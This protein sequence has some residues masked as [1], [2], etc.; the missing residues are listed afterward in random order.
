MSHRI[1]T[2]TPKAPGE[3]RKWHNWSGSVTGHPKNFAQPQSVEE[4]RQI[5]QQTAKAGGQLRVVGAGHSFTPLVQTDDTLLSL[6]NWQGIEHIEKDENQHDI[7]TVRAGTRLNHLG[8]LLHANG[9][10]QENL[11]DIDVQSIAG[12]ISTGTHGTGVG[13]GTIATQVVGLTL[14][15]AQGEELECSSE[16]NPDIFQAAQVS[17]GSLGVLARIKLRTVPSK[18]LHYRSQRETLTTCLE[19]LERY[20]Q[21]NSHFEFYLFPHT[22]WVQTKFARETEAAPNAGGNIWSTLNQVVL[23][24]W[25]YGLLSESCRLFPRLTPTVSHISA[26][27]ISNVDEVDYSHLVF[28]TPRW[29]RFQEM[30]Y[31]IPAEHFTTVLNEIHQCIEKNKFQV[32]FP[33]ECRFVREDGIWLSPA[34]QR[35]SA[36]IAVH[37]YRGMPYKEYFQAIEEIFQRYQGRPHWGKMHTLTADRLATLYPRWDDFLNI[38]AQLDPDGV[39]LNPY[40]RSL[41]AI[42]QANV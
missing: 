14:I 42:P 22:Q 16:Q 10:A 39:F 17:L 41:L 24:N 33:I 25:L 27:G 15:T 20:K 8:K 7:V 34:Y 26:L 29:V 3:G 31:N 19:N 13:F 23:E 9:L 37:M 6:D 1:Q 38:R 18:R 12:A 28:A 2:A 40:L 36:Y 32:H 4:L 5:V 35:N 21:E 30:E 11:G